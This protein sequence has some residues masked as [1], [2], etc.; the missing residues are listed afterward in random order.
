M[1]LG[2]VR[3]DGRL[4]LDALA[5]YLQD[6]GNDDTM[7]RGVGNGGP[8]VARR[9]VVA[10]EGSR[11]RYLDE[12]ELATFPGGRG[13]LVVERR[14]DI[15]HERGVI[16]AATVWAYLDPTSMRPAAVPNWF[17]ELYGAVTPDRKVSHR[18]QLATPDATA[19]RRPWPLRA[20]DYDV[21]EH[22][23]N[24]IAWAAIEDE[25]R[26]VADR[27]RVVRA[28]VEYPGAIDIDDDV[29]L[30]SQHDG[31]SLQL[32][33]TVGDEVRVAARVLLAAAAR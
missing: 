11:P 10:I 2:D 22:V 24:A 21:L 30:V 12:V 5:R 32:W 16:R 3:T 4:R 14:T 20:T 15:T 33:L 31:E 9:T 13:R 26:Q 19:G 8:W 27:A 7:D 25:L 29:E 28:E 23:N 17:D 6:A 18:L 1:R